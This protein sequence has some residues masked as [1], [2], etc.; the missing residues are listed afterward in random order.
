[1]LCVRWPPG[2]HLTFPEGLAPRAPQPCSPGPGPGPGVP[3]PEESSDVNRRPRVHPDDPHSC[4]V[5]CPHPV[6]GA[7]V[8]GATKGRGELQQNEAVQWSAGPRQAICTQTGL[9]H[10]DQDL[11]QEGAGGPGTRAVPGRGLDGQAVAGHPEGKPGGGHLLHPAHQAAQ[12]QR[13]STPF[14]GLSLRMA[15]WPLPQNSRP[16]SCPGFPRPGTPGQGSPSLRVS[17]RRGDGEGLTLFV[18]SPFNP[19]MGQRLTLFGSGRE[20]A[21]TIICF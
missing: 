2:L 5:S 4:R 11:R 19:Q 12:Q 17:E 9:R 10:E 21:L 8:Q 13:P 16:S 1:M 7:R 14:P 6:E 3:F 18:I 20:K 15:Q